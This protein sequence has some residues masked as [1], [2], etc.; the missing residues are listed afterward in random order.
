MKNNIIEMCKNKE[1]VVGDIISYTYFSKDYKRIISNIDIKNNYLSVIDDKD[2]HTLLGISNITNLK[3]SPLFPEKKYSAK[4]TSVLD[5]YNEYLS[6]NKDTTS[7]IR[8]T[9]REDEDFGEA[10]VESIQNGTPSTIGYNKVKGYW[11]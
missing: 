10:I 5:K 11:E 3:K 2:E 9:I 8:V 7:H 4:Y 6:N 1:L